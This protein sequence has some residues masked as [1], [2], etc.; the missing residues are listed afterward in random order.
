MDFLIDNWMLILV[1]LTSGAMLA[2]PRVQGSTKGV[3][4]GAAVQLIN[5]EKAVIIDVCEPA[6]YAA[7]HIAGARNV[8]LGE[9]EAKLPAAAKNKARP[10]ILVCASGARAGRAAGLARKLGYEDVRT[11]AGGLKSWRE[12]NLPIEH[13]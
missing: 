2:W 13:A 4:P 8:P 3:S 7:E 5:S 10:L 9:F 11:L 1:A 12:A 6:E